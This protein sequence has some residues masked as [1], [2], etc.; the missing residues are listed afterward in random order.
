MKSPVSPT[1]MAIATN[2]RP[3]RTALSAQRSNRSVVV[4][5]VA[6]FDEGATA[7]PV[8]LSYNL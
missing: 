2:I 4:S 6:E 3:R 1:M 5:I 7:G 8:I